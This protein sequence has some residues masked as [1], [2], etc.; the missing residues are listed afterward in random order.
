MKLAKLF[1]DKA[2]SCIDEYNAVEANSD[3]IAEFSMQ[4]NGEE[5]T[6]IKYFTRESATIYMSTNL[7]EWFKDNIKEP[8]LAQQYILVKQTPIEFIDSWRFLPSTL[9]KIASYLEN[10]PIAVN[11]FRSD[12][13]T[14]EK[15]NLLRHKGIFPYDF[16]DGLDKLMSTKLPNENQF[17]NK[18]T[19]SHISEKDYNHAVQVWKTFNIRTLGEYS[20]LYLKTD[21]LLLADV[22][23]S[24][25]ETSLKMTKL[26]LELLTDIDMLMFIEAGIRGGI[27]QCC[28]RY[29]KA[30]NPYMGP[31][32]DKEQKIKTLLYF[33]INNLYGWAMVQPLPVGKFKWIEYE[34][35]PSFFNTPP[36]AD[37]GYFAE[38]DLEY[39]EDLHDDHRDLPFCAEHRTPPNSKQKKLLTTL[40]DKTKYVIH[41]RALKQALDNGTR[42][43]KVHR[44]LSFEQ[45]ARLKPYVELNTEK[46]KQSKYEFELFYKLLINAVY[47]KCIERERSRVDVRL[48]KRTSITIKK[49]IYVGLCILDLSKTLVYDFHYL[50]MKQRVGEKCKLLYTDTDSLIYEVA[51]IDMY[52]IMKNNKHKFDTSDYDEN[53]QFG[54]PRVN[55]KVSGLMKDECC[56]KIMTEFVGLR[57]KMYS[58]LIEGGE[59]VKK[60]KG[61]KSNVVKKSITF[62]DY[63][64]CLQDLIIIQRE[65]CN[66]RSKLHIVHTE[67]Q[68]KIAT[69]NLDFIA[70]EFS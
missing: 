4:K 15:I 44:I 65:Q 67:K 7:E 11:E 62:E 66:I 23:E 40:N 45:K 31:S 36:D 70:S 18:L 61:I 17:Y 33:D 48:L 2:K 22:F 46:R 69:L 24:F 12:G 21:V 27:S 6:D 34:T 25:R 56:G 16:V 29:A 26:E 68:E 9:E 43:K 51:D 63:R 57:S 35:N 10:V 42:L 52:Q 30:N 19:D 38:V 32:Y 64:R 28:N 53:N 41:Y 20:D 1:I 50:Y 58:I 55:K 3:F 5:T 47:G 49:P 54:I 8:I 59:T 39:P 37:I 14:N 60:A 13:F